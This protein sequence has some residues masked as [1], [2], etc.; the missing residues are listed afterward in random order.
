MKVIGPSGKVDG[1]SS[2]LQEKLGT[3]RHQQR[4]DKLKNLAIKKPE[5]LKKLANN[6][7]SWAR[8]N[9]VTPSQGLQRRLPE[10]RK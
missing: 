6:W 3:L 8:E 4:P 7:T 5:L 1:N 2:Q 9:Q 10:G